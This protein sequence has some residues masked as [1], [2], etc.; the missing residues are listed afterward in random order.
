MDT[1]WH[2]INDLQ[3]DEKLIKVEFVPSKANLADGA[4]KNV[5]GEIYTSYLP[6]YAADKDY[7]E[8]E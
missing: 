2:Y 7:L 1:R 5:S 3:N 8:K 4:T 6:S